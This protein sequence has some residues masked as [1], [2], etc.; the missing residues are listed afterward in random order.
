MEK[1]PKFIRALKIFR[2][3]IRFINLKFLRGSKNMI[4]QYWTLLRKIKEFLN[5]NDIQRKKLLN[6]SK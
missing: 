1:Q 5:D 2:R 4:K 3:L 6:Q